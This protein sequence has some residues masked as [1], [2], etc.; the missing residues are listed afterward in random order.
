MMSSNSLDV[1]TAASPSWQLRRAAAPLIAVIIL[2]ALPAIAAGVKLPSLVGLATQIL[3]YAIA[4]TSLNLILGYGGM[5]SFGHAAFFGLGG[6][7]AGIL[8]Q[9]FLDQTD[10]LGVAV[11]SNA[12]PVVL[13][14]ALLVGALAGGA[15]GGLSLRTSGVAFIMI[16]LAFAQMLYFLFA[17]LKV[18]GG[19]DGLMMRRRDILPFV[20]TAND[21]T[22]YYICLALALAWLVITGCIVRSQFGFV[23]CGLR[24]NE[25]RMAAIGVSPYRYKLVAFV[26]ASMG[27][28]LAGALM[29]NQ[30]R[31]VG[32][33]FMHW[34]KS[35]DLLMMVVLGGSGT[36]LGPFLGAAAMIVLETVLAAW[37]ENWQFWLGMVLLAIVMF[38]HGGLIGL[39]SRLRGIKP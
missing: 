38:S 33:D 34:T 20:D 17:S 11:G 4:A 12:L 3:I 35:G 19:D 39:L 37:T 24:Q 27:A 7:I 16:T 21:V 26:A 2:A 30:L 1:A 13:I 9:L 5:V 22:Y 28:A 23:L 6:Y 10:L 36:L 31:F 18:Y 15:I 8:Y 25:R 14:A 29:A 32:P